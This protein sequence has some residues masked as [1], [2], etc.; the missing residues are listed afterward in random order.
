MKRPRVYSIIVGVVAVCLAGAVP[1]IAGSRKCP[2]DSVKVGTNCIDTYEASVWQ[3]PTTNTKLVKKVQ[4]GKAKLADLNASGA[5]QLALAETCAQPS[6]YG[7]NFPDTGNWTP[8]LGSN[9]PSPG[10][11]AVSI[12]GVLPSACITW[13]QANQACL[14]S[15]K[16]LLTNREWQG[17]AAGTPDPGTDN[18]TTDCAVSSP[19]PVNTGSRSNCKSSWGV[20]DMVGN[21]LEWVADWA[22]HASA[23]T[24]WTTQTGIAGD[25]LSC[26]GGNGSGGLNQIPGA[27]MR[28]G[29]WN[30]GGGSGVF[31]VSALAH[32]GYANSRTGFRC[33]R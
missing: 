1:V 29:S 23:C 3:I 27:L 17:A 16:R 21:V 13:F 6:Q 11:Y 28:G 32:P 20:F 22:D 25:D 31:L 33:A 8:V 7:T 26:F 12:P 24:D 5:T 19:D 2:P 10:V 18:Q 9:P 15:G 4:D 14:L 30:I